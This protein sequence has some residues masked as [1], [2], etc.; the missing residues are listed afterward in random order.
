MIG[1][2]LSSLLLAAP[3][4]N[5]VEVRNAPA[6]LLAE[7]I[8][9]RLDL[10][11]VE[12]VR[13]VVSAT[14]TAGA[15]DVAVEAR[16]APPGRAVDRSF[17]VRIDECHLVPR[18]VAA[19]VAARVPPSR[20]EAPVETPPPRRPVRSLPTTTDVV[21]EADVALSGSAPPSMNAALDVALDF[22]SDGQPGLV[23]A[24]RLS[25]QP[26]GGPQF[27]FSLLGEL[28]PDEQI[29]G[30]LRRRAVA[31]SAG[32]GTTVDVGWQLGGFA[33]VAGGAHVVNK[34]VYGVVPSSVTDVRPLLD[35]A[36]DLVVQ[37]PQGLRIGSGITVRMLRHRWDWWL[38]RSTVEPRIHARFWLGWGFGASQR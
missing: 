7:D 17:R 26:D 19:I 21:I 25:V 31:A 28:D 14:V 27:V 34:H 1:V 36:L 11:G 22:G 33:S 16:A 12:G 18:A 15:I 4:G 6:C 8:A 13:V 3:N 10:A 37:S 2:L 38:G 23:G 32:V 20:A 24:L 30:T 5:R 35:G 9:A 29:F